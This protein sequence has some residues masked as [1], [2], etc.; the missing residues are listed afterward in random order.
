MK[1][2]L[3]IIT[4]ITVLGL[5]ASQAQYI[6]RNKRKT[7]DTTKVEKTEKTPQSTDNQSNDNQA[8]SVKDLPFSRRLTFGGNIWP[9]FGNPTRIDIQPLLG[10]RFTNK[11]TA[12]VGVNYHYYRIKFQNSAIPPFKQSFYGGRA[13]GQ[14]SVID[15]LFLW[16]EVDGTQGNYFNIETGQTENRLLMSPM[17]GAGYNQQFG[18]FGGAS[19]LVLYNFNYFNTQN[20]SLYTSPWVI[21]TGFMF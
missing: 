2:L 8:A 18:G 3:L 6:P 20:I 4:L 21:R 13:F 7:T 10:Y 11:L 17:L 12:G 19:L 9:Q 16:A 1:K 14:Y 5:Q 15:G